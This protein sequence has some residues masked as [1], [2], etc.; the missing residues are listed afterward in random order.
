[1]RSGAAQF[2]TRGEDAAG[3]MA[4]FVVSFG[5]Y[6]R[7]GRRRSGH[8]EDTVAKPL[9]ITDSTFD[10]EVLQSDKMVLVDFWAPWCGPCR[11]IGP[12]LEEIADEKQDL[13]KVVKVNIDEH[14]QHAAKFRVMTIPAMMLFKDGEM[15]DRLDGAMPKR[16]ILSRLEQHVD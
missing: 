8:E 1:L 6:W 7:C 3:Q 13:L 9:N 2:A 10:Q 12:V 15:V 16:M 5:K 14:Q 4:R 11:S